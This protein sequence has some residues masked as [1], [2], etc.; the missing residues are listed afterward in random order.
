MSRSTGVHKPAVPPAA[1]T[2]QPGEKMKAQPVGIC[3]LGLDS[4][5]PCIANT[6]SLVDSTRSSMR[7]AFLLT[8]RM[9]F[10][11]PSPASLI[12]CSVPPDVDRRRDHQIRFPNQWLAEFIFF[13]LSRR[14]D[15]HIAVVVRAL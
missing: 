2:S 6:S 11:V 9:C 15:P 8:A 4:R 12:H 10:I 7:C 1:S 14:D 5:S 3:V 13:T